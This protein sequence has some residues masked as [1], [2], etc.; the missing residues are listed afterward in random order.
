MLLPSRKRRVGTRLEACFLETRSGRR[1]TLVGGTEDTDHKTVYTEWQ[2]NTTE[3]PI[4]GSQW[5]KAP[6][7]P[8]SSG[9][10]A[11]FKRLVCALAVEVRAG[12]AAC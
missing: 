2:A 5:Q 3:M 12:A 11:S 9:H 6:A 4:Y 1:K 8:G 10:L 7:R